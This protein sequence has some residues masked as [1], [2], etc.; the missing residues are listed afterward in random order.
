MWWPIRHGLE[1]EIIHYL[2][3]NP[4]FTGIIDLTINIDGLPIFKSSKT[5]FWPIL[6][7]LYDSEPFLV[8]LYYGNSKPDPVHDYL[9]DLIAE[10][11]VLKWCP[12]QNHSAQSN[13]ASIRM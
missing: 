6:A 1:P 13:S 9:F 12:T 3:Q 11:Q 10:L 5:H 4:S 7:K 8:A 2:S